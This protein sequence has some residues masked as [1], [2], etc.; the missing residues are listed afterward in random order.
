MRQYRA[1]VLGI[2]LSVCVSLAGCVVDSTKSAS[3]SPASSPIASAQGEPTPPTAPS[4]SSGVTGG[5]AG[6]ETGGSEVVPPVVEGEPGPPPEAGE[7]QSRAVPQIIYLKN[8]WKP[9][10][11]VNIESG[12]LAAGPIQ[13]G[14][15]SAMW[16]LEPVAGTVPTYYRIRNVWKPD[17]YVNIESGALAAGPIQPGWLSA[18]WTLEPVAGT[19]PT[20]YRIRNLW[21]P[22]QYVNIESGAL[23]AGPI[24]PGWLSAMWTPQPV[25]PPQAVKPTFRLKNYWKSN[26]Y[27]NIESGAVQAS[28]IQPGWLSA[29]W[30]L[31]PVAPRSGLY[32]I[33]NVWKPDQYLNIE[34]GALVAGAIQPGWLSAQWTLTGVAGTVPRLYRIRNVW[35]PDQYLNIES[36]ALAA[37]AIQPGWLSAMWT[38]EPMGPTPPPPAAPSD[39]RITSKGS[40]TMNIEWTDNSDNERQFFVTWGRSGGAMLTYSVNADYPKAAENG[41][42]AN[43]SYC[44]TVQAENLGGFSAPTPQVCDSTKPLSGSQT[45]TQ[46]VTLS[47]QNPGGGNYIPFTAMFPAFG[48]PII[49]TLTQI[50]NLDIPL[51]HR[52]IAFVRIGHSTEECGD[53]NAIVMLDPGQ[54]TTPTTM[55][56]IYGTS[57]PPTNP[58]VP[59]LACTDNPTPQ[60]LYIRITYTAP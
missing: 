8:Y 46:D 51:Q 33:R 23:A 5:A 16:T 28:A 29:Q 17:Q 38:I 58:P 37:G 57:T 24:Q 13:P 19:V 47:A 32:R 15:L 11:Y 25:P 9:D 10:Q 55:K 48:N 39:L 22:D 41:L 53:P 14:W 30:T 35:K 4:S 42:T 31:E 21:K 56:D 36:G 44:F 26:Q 54:S 60:L 59:F 34:S 43:T 20:Y 7:V 49:G 52:R 6:K 45:K 27:V 40:T 1:T 18:M 2:V 50:T 3:D 12:A